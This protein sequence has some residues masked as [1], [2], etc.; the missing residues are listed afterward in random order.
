MMSPCSRVMAWHEYGSPPFTAQRNACDDDDDDDE[1]VFLVLSFVGGGTLATLQKAQGLLVFDPFEEDGTDGAASAS[2]AGG[3]RWYDSER[4]RFGE[5]SARLLAGE[6]T[7]VAVA[8]AVAVAV[9]VAVTAS[10]REREEDPCGASGASLVSDIVLLLSVATSP[11]PP[12]ARGWLA[13]C[14]W[15]GQW[16]DMI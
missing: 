13:G 4:Q 10:S 16:G 14:C 3:L 1:S 9:T 6:V 15:S 2:A 8:V 7:T 11:P 5:R 12:V